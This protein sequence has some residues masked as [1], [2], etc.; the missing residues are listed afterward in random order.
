MSRSFE[1]SQAEKRQHQLLLNLFTS[2]KQLIVFNKA[3]KFLQRKKNELCFYLRLKG[4]VS[5]SLDVSQRE[6]KS[7]LLEVIVHVCMHACRE[8]GGCVCVF[9]C[10]WSVYTAGS[11]EQNHFTWPWFLGVSA[12]IPLKGRQALAPSSENK[13]TSLTKYPCIRA[14]KSRAKSLQTLAEFYF[15][16]KWFPL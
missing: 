10:A 15:G 13:R 12:V 14:Q 7:F 6:S 1:S 9:V 8:S 16:G 2:F 3:K 4:K 5:I 11:R